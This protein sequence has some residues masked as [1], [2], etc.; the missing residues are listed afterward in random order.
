MAKVTIVI[1][2]LPPDGG[3]D[4]AQKR[5]SVLFASEPP[6][7]TFPNGDADLGVMTEAQ[8]VGQGMMRAIRGSMKRRGASACSPETASCAETG[9]KERQIMFESASR[10]RKRLEA[11]RADSRLEV[12]KLVNWSTTPSGA[13]ALCG[14]AELLALQGSVEGRMLVT[15]PLIK[16]LS[17]LIFETYSG[18]VYELVGPPDAEFVIFCSRIGKQLDVSD[19]VK[20]SGQNPMPRD[21]VLWWKG[22]AKA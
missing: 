4:G 20:W 8:A 21:H 19:P 12:K 22:M 10:L 6:L 13:F 9:K 18:S 11:A 14:G 16:K 17:P 3:K 15:S 7:K 2:D 5:L 1:E